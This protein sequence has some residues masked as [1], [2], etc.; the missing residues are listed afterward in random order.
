MG[1][2]NVIEDRDYLEDNMCGSDHKEGINRV[3]MMTLVE[4]LEVLSGIQN[5]RQR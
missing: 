3:T 1:R 4:Q 2:K 5:R